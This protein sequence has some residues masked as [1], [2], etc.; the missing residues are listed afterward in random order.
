MAHGILY[1]MLLLELHKKI[2]LEVFPRKARHFPERITSCEAS[3]TRV[4]AESLGLGLVSLHSP[5]QSDMRLPHENASPIWMQDFWGFSKAFRGYVSFSAT[6]QK[7][8]PCWNLT[9]SLRR[10]TNTIENDYNL[11]AQKS[12]RNFGSSPMSNTCTNFQTKFRAMSN[13]LISAHHHVETFKSIL[14]T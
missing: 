7:L 12:F 9:G 11:L 10:V 8:F 14:G 2:S 6:L 1:L 5:P 3:R 13:K 4:G